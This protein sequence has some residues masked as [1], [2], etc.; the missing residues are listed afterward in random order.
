[1]LV[2]VHER[3]DDAVDEHRD[4]L[5]EDGQVHV[6]AERGVRRELA[7]LL[8]DGRRVVAHALELVADVVER[9][10]VAQ[11]ARDRVSGLR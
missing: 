10:Q 6:V 5:A 1:M 3:A 8:R 4:L 11:V 7:R 2:H 9:Q